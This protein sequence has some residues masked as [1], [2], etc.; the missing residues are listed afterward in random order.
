LAADGTTCVSDDC[1]TFQILTIA[2]KCEDCKIDESP[3]ATGKICEKTDSVA[4]LSGSSNV[5]SSERYKI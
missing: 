2:G 5:D 3:D 1:L 4:D